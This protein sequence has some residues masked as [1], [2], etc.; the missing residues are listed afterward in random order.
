MKKLMRIIAAYVK[1]DKARCAVIKR[2]KNKLQE[3]QAETETVT[4]PPGTSQEHADDD[5]GDAKTRLIARIKQFYLDDA[6]STACAGK[7]EFITRNKTRMQK[8][9][10]CLPLKD[11]HKKFQSETKLRVSYS[12]FCTIR[13]FWVLFPKKENRDTCLCIVHTNMQLL[14]EAMNKESIITEKNYDQVLTKMCCDTRNP[15]CLQRN[16]DTCK[17][18]HLEF[19]E[20]ANSDFTFWQW[21]KGCK[22]VTLSNGRKK[23]QTLTE[24]KKITMSTAQAIAKFERDL[25][26]FLIHTFKIVHQYRE[27][28]S[29]KENLRIQ[30]ACVHVDFSENY[31]LKFAEEVQSFHFGGSRQQVSLHTSVIY[32]HSFSTGQVTAT[33]MCTI[34]DCLRHDAPAIWAHLVPLI[35][36]VTK[37]NPFIDTLHFLSDSPSSQYRNKYMFFIMSQICK[38]FPQITRVTWN[39][40]EAGHGKGAPD[41]VG[42]TL[43][44]TAD[45]MVIY[46]KDV[47]TFDQFHDLIVESVKNDGLNVVIKKIDEE[48]VLLKQSLI[49]PSLKP[50]K[51]TFSVYQVLWDKAELKTTLRTMSC[52]ECAASEICVHG[53]HLGYIKN[54]HAPIKENVEPTHPVLSSEVTYLANTKPDTVK[55]NR[56][57]ILSDVTS[58]CN[59]P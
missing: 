44:R 29:L 48:D 32:T 22:E 45:R 53:K 38:D 11:M 23:K 17:S 47:G 4:L 5:S 41:G 46:G 57:Q 42:A 21:Q 39:Y 7:R 12:F 15:N 34:S 18:N 3:A 55:K 13:P 16:C 9:Y 36:E 26:I 35:E 10:L 51:G 33:S 20:F 31:S 56:I 25:T 2:L 37:L 40:T 58:Y 50:F 52:F 59:V 54:V 19:K 43:K 14:I 27:L 24:K 49:P 6:N 1:K 8:R 28:K 30:E